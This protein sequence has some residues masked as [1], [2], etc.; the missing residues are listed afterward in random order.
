MTVGAPHPEFSLKD[1][2]QKDVNV[3]IFAATSA[4]SSCSTRSI[5]A[6]SAPTNMLVSSTR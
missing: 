2:N 3:T 4:S 6:R 1:Q 5:G